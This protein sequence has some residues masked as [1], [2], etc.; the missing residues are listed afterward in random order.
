[1]RGKS[2]L[3]DTGTIRGIKM[4]LLTAA[5]SRAIWPYLN[6][7]GEPTRWGDRW[8]LHEYTVAPAD[9][10]IHTA[11]LGEIS[12][13]LPILESLLGKNRIAV[14][15]T[16]GRSL[17]AVTRKL[18]GKAQVFPLPVDG[19]PGMERLF[20][21]LGV[22][23]LFI[24]EAEFWPNLVKKALDKGILVYFIGAR[25]HGLKNLLWRL[26][27]SAKKRRDFIGGVWVSTEKEKKIFMG[28]GIPEDRVH[29]G[30]H[31]KLLTPDPPPLQSPF[32]RLNELP[33]PRI[34]AGS[35]HYGE[36]DLILDIFQQLRL[37]FPTLHLLLVPRHPYEGSLFIE[38]VRYRGISAGIWPDLRTCTLID[39]FGVLPSLYSLGNAAMVGGA[40][41][42]RG[43]HNP[44]EPLYQG[45]PV[46][47]GPHHHH[48]AHLLPLLPCDGI[49]IARTM[50]EGVYHLSHFIS[51]PPS[52]R[53]S[54]KERLHE[55]RNK[56]ES[57][58]KTLFTLNP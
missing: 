19:G 30:F 14:T 3:R 38:R 57:L 40:W 24:L 15:V 31:A 13:F 46:V 6:S 8:Y 5:L 50:E 21:G 56:T 51:Q 10:W 29:S 58:I 52:T 4:N 53:F 33:L 26:I 16:S 54:W 17:A 55:E 27:L 11:S 43:G 45:V 49:R 44:V 20:G 28:L 37:Q 18:E 9:L 48:L 1:M 22:R 25:T 42:K 23:R 34:V 41:V 2:G 32:D 36:L 39:R 47:L 7:H 35:I 12:P